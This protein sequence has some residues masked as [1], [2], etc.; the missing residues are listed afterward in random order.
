MKQTVDK[1]K[2]MCVLYPLVIGV[3]IIVNGVLL[4]I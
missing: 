3:E 1:S 2:R 4:A